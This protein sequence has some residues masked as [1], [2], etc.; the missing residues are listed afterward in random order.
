MDQLICFCQSSPM[1]QI[2]FAE[3]CKKLE[4]FMQAADSFNLITQSKKIDEYVLLP[5]LRQAM[6][7]VDKK[8]AV[9]IIDHLARMHGVMNVVESW[10]RQSK[11]VLQTLHHCSLVSF[12]L[13][14]TLCILIEASKHHWKN[15]HQC[16]QFK[17][18]CNCCHWICPHALGLLA[19]LK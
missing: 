7:P 14:I 6:P 11:S 2:P 8:T 18:Y 17:C 5:S 12:L 1:R 19:N 13:L 3:W 15:N 4:P 16:S 10:W 9:A